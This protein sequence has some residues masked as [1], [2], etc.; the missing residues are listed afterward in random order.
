M[1]DKLDFQ[2]SF[3]SLCYENLKGLGNMICSDPIKIR[4]YLVLYIGNAT[5]DALV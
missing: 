4:I 2:V 3:F 1:L 5:C